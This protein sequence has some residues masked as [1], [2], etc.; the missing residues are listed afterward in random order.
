MS[1]SDIIYVTRIWIEKIYV[2]LP[3]RSAVSRPRFLL[4]KQNEHL[5]HGG[6]F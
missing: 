6:N 4:P 5:V 2:L 1:H 3:I